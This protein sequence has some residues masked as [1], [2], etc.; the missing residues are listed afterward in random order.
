MT[1]IVIQSNGG[2]ELEVERAT[3][4]AGFFPDYWYVRDATGTAA[5][6]VPTYIDA[7]L[8]AAV[9][10]QTSKT[11]AALRAAY[12]PQGDQ[13]VANRQ[14]AINA[15]AL[16]PFHAALANR[17][18][19]PCDIIVTGTSISQG[20]GA[21]HFANRY[22][23]RLLD[24]LRNRF[25]VPGVTGG[26][27]FV[28]FDLPIVPPVDPPF[29]R[30]GSGSY[31]DDGYGLAR[32][33][34]TLAA[35]GDKVTGSFTG[36]AIDIWWVQYSSGG[37]VS[38]SI[39]GGA[40][41]NVATTG[42]G[43]SGGH[44]FSVTG[45]T[46]GSHTLTIAYVSGGTVF[47]NGA[48]IYNGD[49]STGI[50]MWGGGHASTQSSYWVDPAHPN[51]LDEVAVIQPALH[52]L[53]VATNDY[54]QTPGIDPATMKANVQQVVANIRGV[55]S[56]SIVLLPTWDRSL[57]V[58]PPATWPTYV[59]ALY[60]LAKADGNIAVADAYQW[61]GTDAPPVNGLS[62]DGVHPSDKGHSFLA[63]HLAQFLLPR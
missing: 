42:S 39:D 45:L 58:T 21:S 26:I 31:V 11:S 38:V 35:A 55:A 5:P 37:T 6:S 54:G 16:R 9:A 10:D 47:L 25:P 18:F 29:A 23:N 13:Q 2:P 60:D 20:V 32:R 52:I 28:P 51:W 15:D 19:A 57:S 63:D 62:A 48:T 50:R 40:A 24:Q 8:A 44:R 46:A 56:P 3:F 7:D 34:V 17:F 12:V 36:T 41:T 43:V 59:Q 49:S 53:E 22:T 30:S 4:D 1:R 61:F 33:A 14:T 27:G